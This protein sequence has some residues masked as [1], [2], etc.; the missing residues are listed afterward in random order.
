MTAVSFSPDRNLGV[1]RFTYQN[2]A[3]LPQIPAIYWFWF[4]NRNGFIDRCLYVGQ[5]AALRGRLLQH[6][7]SSSNRALQRWIRAY[8]GDL[9]FE[10][11]KSAP[12]RLIEDERRFIRQLHPETNIQGVP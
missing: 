5:S 10:F 3:S 11:R 6:W 4:P 8:G 2:I 7:Q 12:D 1:L 9:A